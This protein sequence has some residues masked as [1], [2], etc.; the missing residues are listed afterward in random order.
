MKALILAIGF[1]SFSPPS[2]A[3]PALRSLS[4]PDEWHPNI[5]GQS[6]EEIRIGGHFAL[7]QQCRV[8]A[9]YTY[10]LINPPLHGKVCF[11]MERS[12][13]K[14]GIDRGKTKCVGDFVE[15]RVVYYKSNRNYVGMDHFSYVAS[16]SNQP[17]VNVDVNLI[18]NSTA[19]ISKLSHKQPSR[20]SVQI[21]SPE[22]VSECTRL[23]P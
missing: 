19:P 6:N 13:I 18:I 23:S 8:R 7:D 21:A 14:E 4:Q 16:D 22:L 15:S 5:T 1:L 20:F 9:L 3:D 11:K 10:H 17:Q 12:T 2:D